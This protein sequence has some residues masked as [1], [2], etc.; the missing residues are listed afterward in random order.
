[1]KRFIQLAII[2]TLLATTLSG[3][4]LAQDDNPANG[5]IRGAVFSDANGDGVCVNTGVDGEV[6]LPNISLQFVNSDGE[7]TMNHTTGADGTFGLV[8]VGQSHWQVTVQAPEGW[9]VSGAESLFALID[10]NNTLVEN[11]NF[12]LQSTGA[13]TQTAVLL[14]E[15]GGSSSAGLTAVVAIGGLLLVAIGL[16]LEA[17]R[18]FKA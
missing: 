10:D 9:E 13:T 15:A 12:C 6:G 4:L 2:L 5:T 16:L 18:R 7:I 1:M 14:P 3:V 8:S 17:R 11:V